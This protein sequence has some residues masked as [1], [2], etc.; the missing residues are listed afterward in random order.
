VDSKE[1]AGAKKFFSSFDKTFLSKGFLITKKYT[2]CS[3]LNVLS[4]E[5]LF[6]YFACTVVEKIRDQ[7]K[8]FCRLAVH[9][10][11]PRKP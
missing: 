10:A 8:K 6:N 5:L 1:R 9:C 4:Y 7:E 11:F 2:F 3:T